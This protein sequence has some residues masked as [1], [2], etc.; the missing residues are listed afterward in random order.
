MQHW[1]PSRLQTLTMASLPPTVHDDIA[2]VPQAGEG[3][4]LLSCLQSVIL[5]KVLSFSVDMLSTFPVHEHS[6]A[7]RQ[8]F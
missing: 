7:S 6:W 8:M 5:C 3:T 1:A 4:R 2:D